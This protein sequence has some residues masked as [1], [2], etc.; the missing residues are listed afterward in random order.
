MEMAATTASSKDEAD[1][2]A[3]NDISTEQKAKPWHGCVTFLLL[4]FCACLSTQRRD[5]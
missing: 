4:S 5:V 1:A 3:S 2:T